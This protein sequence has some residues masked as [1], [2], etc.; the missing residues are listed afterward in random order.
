VSNL[1]ASST[2]P[3]PTLLL[4]SHNSGSK[5]NALFLDLSRRAEAQSLVPHARARV[6]Q[7]ALILYSPSKVHKSA[8]DAAA[9]AWHEQGGII[10]D[11][12]GLAPQVSD[13]SAILSRLLGLTQSQQRTGTLKGILTDQLPVTALPRIRQDLDV[14]FLFTD[15]ATARLLKPQIDFHYAGKLPVYS[16]NTIFSGKADVVNDLDLEGMLFSDMPWLVRQTGR[17]GRASADS[18]AATDYQHSAI[19]R[20]FALGLD[21]YR[22]TCHIPKRQDQPNWQYAGA[23]GRISISVDGRIKRLPDW[24]TFN[25][26]SPQ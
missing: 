5:P 20:L 11:R 12:A 9:T 26:G 17:F 7:H 15:Q 8:A 14:I 19:G 13:Y 22:L 21:A 24:A 10:A 25:K 6:L 18:S 3:V 16:Q 2:L 1:V 4:G 23:S